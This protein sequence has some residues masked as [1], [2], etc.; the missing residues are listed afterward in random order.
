M[1]LSRITIGRAF[2]MIQKGGVARQSKIVYKVETLL[3]RHSWSELSWVTMPS[4]A[5]LTTESPN[6][7]TTTCIE[8]GNWINWERSINNFEIVLFI[9]F[10]LSVTTAFIYIIGVHF[11]SRRPRYSLQ[12]E[13]IQPAEGTQLTAL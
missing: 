7:L 1:K 13:D 11:Y 2:Y 12:Q 3:A 10:I 4:G 6:I 8:R 9:T 5:N